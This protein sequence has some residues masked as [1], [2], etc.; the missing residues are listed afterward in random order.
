MVLLLTT[1]LCVTFDTTRLLGIFE[2][3][4][5][6]ICFHL[7]KPSLWQ[8][9]GGFLLGVWVCDEKQ[10]PPAPLQKRGGEKAPDFFN[11]KR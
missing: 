11:S 10:I 3:G 6:V 8:R 5:G 2:W 9:R 1:L 4:L 7:E